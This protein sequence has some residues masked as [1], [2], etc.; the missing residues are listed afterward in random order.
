MRS[1]TGCTVGFD[2]G[3]FTGY[4]D[5]RVGTL[6]SRDAGHVRGDRCPSCGG[7]AGSAG[8]GTIKWSIGDAEVFLTD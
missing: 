5:W 7:K 6:N 2:K 1:Q 8:K 4:T 3:L